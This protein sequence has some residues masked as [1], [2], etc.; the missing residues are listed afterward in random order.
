MIFFDKQTYILRREEL[1]KRVGSGMLL[2][3]GNNNAPANYPS[4]AYV[5]RQD[6]SF[7]YY[8]GHNQEGLI[9]VIDIDNNKEYLLG[10]D[11]DIEDI[12]WTG[13]VP[14]IQDLAEEIGV[15]N[16]APLSKLNDLVAG[17]SKVHYLP[18]CRFDT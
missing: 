18:P 5:F 4:N 7:L 10:D 12:I 3:F 6:S 2:F 8:F 1:K 17:A 11:V 15:T 9:G 13:F 14:S 16:S